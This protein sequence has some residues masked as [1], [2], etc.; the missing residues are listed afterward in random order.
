MDSNFNI[1]ERSD[2]Q[3]IKDSDTLRA[4]DDVVTFGAKGG[5]SIFTTPIANNLPAHYTSI[6]HQRFADSNQLIDHR[7]GD[8]VGECGY[9]YRD[10]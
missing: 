2:D 10:K 3:L 7:T 4:M 8:V 6:H 1:Y 9:L 5:R